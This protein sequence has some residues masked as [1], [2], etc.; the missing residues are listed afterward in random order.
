ML[1][2]RILWLIK[3]SYLAVKNKNFNA[4][5]FSF[6]LKSVFEDNVILYGFTSVN[7]SK[8]GRY[9][10]LNSAK[11]SNATIG[12]FCS[13]GYQVIIGGGTHPANMGSTHPVFYSTM[14]QAGVCFVKNNK[15]MEYKETV[16]GNDV[17]IGQRCILLDGVIVGDGAIIAAGS[18]VTKNVEPYA[19]VGGVPAKFIKYRLAEDII[20]EL[21][22]IQWWDWDEQIIKKFHNEI[23][24]LNLNKLNNEFSTINHK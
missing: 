8:I 14:K 20:K 10:Y 22:K 9:T 5:L 24:Q 19:I 15:H 12:R 2:K 6:S 23:F 18:V 4:S 21:V 1:I 7:N 11:V 3:K 17:W 13:I 16:I